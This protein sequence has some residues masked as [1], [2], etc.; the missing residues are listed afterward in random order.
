MTDDAIECPL[1]KELALVPTVAA[2][3]ASGNTYFHYECD[4][5]HAELSI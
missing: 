5:C 3:D 4:E 2:I 1:C